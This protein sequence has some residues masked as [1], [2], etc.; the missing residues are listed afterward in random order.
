MIEPHGPGSIWAWGHNDDGEIGDGTT[1]D[2]HTPTQESTGATNWSAVDTDFYHTVA[3][4]SDGT[5]WSWGYSQEGSLGNGTPGGEF[6]YTPLQEKTRATNW[7]AIAAGAFHTVALKS[8]GTIWAWGRPLWG[9][10]GV[11][12]PWDAYRQNMCTATDNTTPTQIGSAT[13]WAA[14]SAGNSY[15]IALKSD[16]T[17]WAWGHNDDGELGDGTTSDKYTP[18]QESTGATNWSAIAAGSSHAVALK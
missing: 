17:L 10:L 2:K 7:S 13:N 8:D 4:K 1:S 12:C 3:L 18:T 14:I 11:A 5:L 16:G 6:S 9:A 15:T